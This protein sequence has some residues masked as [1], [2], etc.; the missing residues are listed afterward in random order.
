[1]SMGFDFLQSSPSDQGIDL[2]IGDLKLQYNAALEEL[3]FVSVSFESY[4]DAC[5]RVFA[6][7]DAVEAN[8]GMLDP[9]VRDFVNRNGELSMALG[10]DLAMEDD[11]QDAQKQNGEKVTEKKQGFFRRVW[12]AIKKFVRWILDKIGSFFHGLG[13]LFAGTKKKMEWV[14][15]DGIKV[16][17]EFAQLP[18]EQQ[19]AI[20]KEGLSATLHKKEGATE[21]FEMGSIYPNQKTQESIKTINE[22][23]YE[24]HQS[25]VWPK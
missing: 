22:H 20:T 10:I 24:I 7:F 11:S 8:E 17:E 18:K 23:N 15:H 6:L 12:E 14:L 25:D 1:M 2:D 5:N 3:S 21:A 16:A 4:M 9:V 19:D 13:N